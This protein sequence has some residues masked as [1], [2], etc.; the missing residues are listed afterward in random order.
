M[1]DNGATSKEVSEN[2]GNL[3]SLAKQTLSK[4]KPIYDF[5]TK[6][7]SFL[8]MYNDL[9]KMGIKNNKFFLKLYDKDLLGVD[10]Y[11]GVIPLDLQM[12]ILLE[13]IINPWY[14]LRE[15]CRI[16]EDGSPIEVGGGT[17]FILDRNNLAS[18]YCFLNGIDHY[19]S[20]ARQCGKTQNAVAEL[21]YAFLFGAIS[22]TFLFFNKDSGMAKQNLY[23]LKCQRDML[24]SFLQMKFAYDA[25]GGIDKGVDNIT[26]VRNPVN[27]N[28]IKVM[29]KATSMDHAVKLGRGETAAFH[30]YD[31]YDFMPWNTEIVKAASFA[32]SKASENARKNGSLHCRIMTSTPGYLSTREGAEAAKQISRMLRWEDKFYDLP[33]NQL[34]SIL[35]SPSYNGIMYIE[36]SWKQL[37]KS[38]QW[39][40]HQCSLVE[41]DPD[42]ILREIELQRVHGNTNSPFKRSTLVFLMQH[43]REP[44]EVI[45]YSNN[46]CPIN[47]YEK[48][49]R[50]ITYILSVDPA[51]GLGFNNN[52]FTLINPY[53]LCAAA[54]FKSPYISPPDFVRLICKFLDEKCPKS[55]IVIEANRGRELIN[56]LLE[57]KY[58]YQLWYDSSKITSKIVETTDRYG[59]LK[60]SANERRAFGFDTTKSTRPLLFSILENM[61]E[62][63]IHKLYTPYIVKDITSVQR[64]PNGAII[65]SSNDENDEGVGH[66]D[67]LMSYLIGLYVYHNATNLEEFGIIKGASEP[68]DP[69][70]PETP[71]EKK[72]KIKSLMGYLPK[73]LQNLFMDVI[74]E[75]DDKSIAWEYEKQIQ[76][77]LARQAA[78][79]GEDQT[80]STYAHD[81]LNE[82]QW[83]DLTRRIMDN[84]VNRRTQLRPNPADPLIPYSDPYQS[85]YY[86]NNGPY[87]TN[88]GGFDINRYID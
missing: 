58:R 31:E 66:G 82:S 67:N 14:F 71:E 68:S 27:G 56:R 12:K 36:H 5:K 34:K 53:T 65:L 32:Y 39:Y 47:I 41:Y 86:G 7:K 35:K 77:E 85:G 11:N 24:P 4:R 46:L 55:L 63:Q 43:I 51:E 74:N 83:N 38:M 79:R 6:N 25:S 29:P 40:E 78:L 33:I 1:I 13:I 72:N 62:E 42:K 88:T 64:K 81:V 20:K 23:R 45:D 37:K 57:T 9:Y 50:K 10:V 18:W 15:I 19:D 49:N 28:T 26:T 30:Y 69:S 54:E 73:D 87:P 70:A 21:N 84:Q 80:A 61:V 8:I 52:A 16:P 2:M 3:V 44:I 48:I 76:E 17:P 59:A 60:Q 22:S 75:Q